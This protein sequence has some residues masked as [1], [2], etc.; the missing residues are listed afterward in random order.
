MNA[1]IKPL[2]TPYR[3]CKFRSRLEAR[4]AVFFDKLGIDWRYEVEGFDI[5]GTWYLPDFFLPYAA[6]EPGWGFWVEIKPVSL[7]PEQIALVDGLARITGH[8]A[9][10][11]CGDPWAGKHTV[12]MFDHY[13]QG[14]PKYIPTGEYI[15]CERQV[16]DGE[17]FLEA[18]LG[19][20]GVGQQLPFTLFGPHVSSGKPI[21]TEA[22]TAARSARFERAVEMPQPTEPDPLK[23]AFDACKSEAEQTQLMLSLL[24]QKRREQGIINPGRPSM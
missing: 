22:F 5:D 10:A 1:N 19:L 15:F 2:E 8:C 3:G 16:F 9:Y 14:T 21:L 20:I 17:N 23:D 4:W 6:G 12:L 11:L 18:E 13:H 7:T 24:E